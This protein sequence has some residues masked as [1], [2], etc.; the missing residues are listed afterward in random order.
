LRGQVHSERERL[1]IPAVHDTANGNW[2]KAIEAYQVVVRTYPR[3]PMAHNNLAAVYWQT[4]QHEKA[5]AEWQVAA[6]EAPGV[7]TSN[8]N[9]V[10]TYI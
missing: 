6:R 1:W 5:L 3:D 10:V 7:A 2:E 9:L 4:G 8:V